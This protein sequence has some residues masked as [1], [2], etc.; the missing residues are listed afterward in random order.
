MVKDVILCHESLF[1][2]TEENIDQTFLSGRAC[3]HSLARLFYVLLPL[4]QCRWKI[5]LKINEADKKLAKLPPT[6]YACL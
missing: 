3:P 6:T 4:F 1:H 2:F 5:D